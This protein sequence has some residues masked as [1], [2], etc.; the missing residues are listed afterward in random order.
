MVG[1]FNVGR[2]ESGVIA[3]KVNDLAR[4]TAVHYA[5][6]STAWPEANVTQASSL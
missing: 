2:V 1:C 6:R 4:T 5:S 3:I